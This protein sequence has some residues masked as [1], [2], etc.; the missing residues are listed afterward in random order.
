[1]LDDLGDFTT[2]DAA[3]ERG[4]ARVYELGAAPEGPGGAQQPPRGDRAQVNTLVIENKG[5]VAILVLAGTVVK[6]GKQ[7]RQIGQD[8]VV[9]ARETT[10]VDA[11]CV[12]HGRWNAVRDGQ[13]TGG[14][15]KAMKVLANGDV[16]AA[17]Q[18]E[19]NQSEVWSSVGKVNKANKKQNASDTLTASLDDKDAAEGREAAARKAADFLAS[20]PVSDHVVGLAY[21]VGGEVQGV[22]WF[23]NHKLFG[24][25]R[26]TLLNTAVVDAATARAEARDAG[27][28]K[29]PGACAPEAVAAF[30]TRVDAGRREDR[31]TEGQNVNSYQFSDEGYA[32]E[33]AMKSS[34]PAAKPKAVT[35]DFLKKKK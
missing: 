23:F 35:K 6:G 20:V 26:D 15:F 7:D 1:V 31:A 13:A 30:V 8:F 2:L 34:S 18:Y 14:Q 33:A 16:R 27:K 10:P 12:E 19:R 5:D 32:A 21:A 25:H 17:G 29:A 4:T 28:P 24:Q 22:R 11:F 9:G 3:L